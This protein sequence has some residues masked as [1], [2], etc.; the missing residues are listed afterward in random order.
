MVAERVGRLAYRFDL[1]PTWEIHPVIST[2]HLEPAPNPD[3][4]GREAQDPRATHD[5]NFPQDT[6]RH[7]MAVVLDSRVHHRHLRRY[8]TPIREY[9]I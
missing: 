8:Y 9:L 7:D 4:F 6:D 5:E 3:P 1:P 2:Q